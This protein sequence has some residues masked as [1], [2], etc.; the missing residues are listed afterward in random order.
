MLKLLFRR[1]ACD[2]LLERHGL[3]LSAEHLARL[4]RT[5]TGPRFHLLGG[6]SERA[7]YARQDLD[8][9]AN[10]YVGPA[11]ASV[12]EHPAHAHKERAA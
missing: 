12:A 2:Y 8:A 11:I 10:A 9:W 3:E 7:A 1:E 5:G 6:R 4:A